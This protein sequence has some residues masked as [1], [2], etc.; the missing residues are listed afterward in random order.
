MMCYPGTIKVLHNTD[1]LKT[2]ADAPLE[3]LLPQLVFLDDK[4]RFREQHPEFVLLMSYYHHCIASNELNIEE[5]S[6]TESPDQQ[7]NQT[8]QLG[9]LRKVD[10]YNDLLMQE[11]FRI[12]KPIPLAENSYFVQ[13]VSSDLIFFTRSEVDGSLG[14]S[15]L[16]RSAL[17]PTEFPISQE[18]SLNEYMQSLIAI[19]ESGIDSVSKKVL[20]E[21]KLIIAGDQS[22]IL[23]FSIYDANEDLFTL[24]VYNVSEGREVASFVGGQAILCDLP[25]QNSQDQ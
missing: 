20:F 13:S 25:T 3:A 15:F 22:I 6:I 11:V 12:Q 7:P 16:A 8:Y 1:A 18:S 9:Y 10:G 2:Q 14:V 17:K 5:E 19:E 24:N 21:P 23:S 4:S